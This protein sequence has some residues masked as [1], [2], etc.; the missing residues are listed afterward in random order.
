MGLFKNLFGSKNK[1]NMDKKNV[2]NEIPDEVKELKSRDR[3]QNTIYFYNFLQRIKPFAERTFNGYTDA[4][5]NNNE[6]GIRNWARG[7]SEGI[8][9]KPSIWYSMGA[10]INKDWQIYY[11]DNIKYYQ[12]CISRDLINGSYQLS[13]KILAIGILLDIDKGVFKKISE[14]YVEEG[15]ED[16]ILDSM[17]HSQYP[18]HPVSSALQFPDEKY[19]QKLSDILKSNSNQEAE[20]IIKEALENYF[21]TRENL[22]T[23]YESHKTEF[24]SGYWAWELGALVKIMGLNDSNF[25]DHD[26]YPYD[27]VHWRTN[28]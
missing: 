8:Y 20:A 10:A 16:F 23:A 27:L 4:K 11:M 21:Y 28:R 7:L 12:E 1:Q 13:L 9:V 25:K 15:Y 14:R 17:I 3:N 24:Y 22:Q 18:E 5:K 6:A 19:I 2:E 26:F